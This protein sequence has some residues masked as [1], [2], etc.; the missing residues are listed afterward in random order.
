MTMTG[1]LGSVLRGSKGGATPRHFFAAVLAGAAVLAP[2]DLVMAHG[3]CQAPV[4]ARATLQPELGNHSMPITTAS[5]DAQRFFNQ[6]L[7]LA[8]AFNHA[9]AASAF[10]EAARLDPNCAMCRWGVALVLGPNINAPMDDSDVSEA[11]TAMREAVRL[12]QRATAKERA[13]INALSRRYAPTPVPDRAPLD[14]AY[15]AAMRDVARRF[16]NDADVN[17]LFAESLMNLH[18]WD[19]WLADGRPQS[20]TPEI[21]AI[22]ERVLRR[23]P[24][25]PGANHYYIH[26]VEASSDPGRAVASADRLRRLAP[27]AGHLVHMSAHIYMRVGRYHDASLANERAIDADRPFAECGVTGVYTA[28]Y[29]PHNHHFLWASA[30]MEGRSEVALRAAR[31]MA[32]LATVGVM[33]RPD[34]G[35]MMQHFWATQLYAYVRFGRWSEILAEPPPPE[36]LR[37][38]SAVSNYARGMAFVRTDRVAEA[39]A[40]QERLA[41]TAEDTAM[42]TLMVGEINSAQGILRVAAELLAAEIAAARGEHDASVRHFEAATRHEDS[43]RYF[44][45]PPWHMPVRQ[46]LGMMLLRAGRAG[47]AEAAFRADLQRNPENGWALYG[48]AAS[49]RAQGK[50]DTAIAARFRTAWSRA[51]IT[52]D[53]PRF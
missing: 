33:R 31:H 48:L 42:A 15:A 34:F 39:Q 38:A 18:P 6:G 11:H 1:L 45:P 28:G 10:R 41:A 4:E 52:R 50:D 51:D 9:A 12:A 24:D 19:F 25:H 32:S 7:T 30:T 3:S 49:L 8:Y 37:Y 53:A 14:A 44:E 21:V 29:V 22:L 16:P 36:D 13:F 26:A 43:L 27:A 46:A 35:P 5:R 40:A 20:W 2:I 47:A 17:T 23:S